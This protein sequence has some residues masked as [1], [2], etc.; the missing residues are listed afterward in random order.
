MNQLISRSQIE[1][2]KKEEK[3][4]LLTARQV[5]KDFAMFGFDV[6]FSGE[7]ARAYD[8][9][10]HQLDA[11]IRRMIDTNYERLMGLLYQIDLSEKEIQR[12]GAVNTYETI[13]EMI[14]HLVLERELKKVLLR[15]YFKEQGYK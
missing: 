12:A 13:S 1:Q 6:K 3:F 5:Q 14:S 10:L 7:A 4:I 9:L 8:E 2:S 15:E 11:H